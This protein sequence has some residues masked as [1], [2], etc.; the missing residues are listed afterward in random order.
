M[1]RAFLCGVSMLTLACSSNVLAANMPMPQKPGMVVKASPPPPS[2]W[3]LEFGSRYWYS[4]G[5]HRFDLSDPTGSHLNSRLTYTGIT[6]HSA[7]SFWRI[8]HT[9][10]FFFKGYFGAGSLINGNLRDEDFPPAIVPF[11][12]TNSPHKDGSL[13]YFSADVGYD[14]WSDM[15]S[16][17]GA[18][19]GIHYW[20]EVM[21][22]FGCT[23]IATNPF[24]C[25][26]IPPVFGPLPD[27]ANGLDNDHT[28]TSAR[29]GVNAT[30][31][32][33]PNLKLTG[34]V[35]Y[36]R[37]Y[38]NET[39]RHN[40]RPT[41]RPE[42]QDALVGN[43][44][45]AEGILSYNVTPAFSVGAGGRYWY[46]QGNG[47][48][49]FFE[50]GGGGPVSP[51][52]FWTER[53][54]VFGQASYKFGDPAMMPMPAP[55]GY[56]MPSVAS[57][58][59]WTGLHVGANAGYGFAEQ[60]TFFTPL[61]GNAQILSSLTFDS[62]ANQHTQDAGFVGGGQIGYDW[63]IGQ[64]VYGIETDLDWANVSG[65]TAQTSLINVVTTT[66]DKNIGSLGTVRA[67]IGKA[68]TNWLLIYATGG[69]A[70]GDTRLSVDQRQPLLNCPF[71]LVCANGSA[72][73]TSVGWVGGIGYEAAADDHFSFT[74]EALYVDLGSR[75]VNTTDTGVHPASF[76][77]PA[78]CGFNYNAST[79][80]NMFLTRFG[81]NYK[82][83][84]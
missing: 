30:V 3:D 61:S 65:T 11:S 15:T 55:K 54:G 46:I 48:T 49:R 23:Q 71:N 45:Q 16:R 58:H 4:S 80:F 62:P 73:G 32:L 38:L 33:A 18:F 51:S 84:G 81:V 19:V 5:K 8:A 29:I 77:C 47:F 40:L 20:N 70:Y 7:E 34:D 6:G 35:A 67:R 69:L 43:G 68:P 14:L 76:L 21:H 42:P 63:Q 66:T 57:A 83:G 17:F 79:H 78:G 9:S 22:T 52:K 44:V 64:Y 74:G 59:V 75:S 26:S 60:N 82:L 12:A 39:D 1:T 27:T 10:G 56:V 37:G 24:V 2:P 41:I 53:Y 31:N 72:S 13:R 50:T 28:W 36:V 25:G